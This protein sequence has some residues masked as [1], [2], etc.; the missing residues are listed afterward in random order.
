M[1]FNIKNKVIH[2]SLS[3]L[4]SL[5]I[6]FSVIPV[7]LLVS[8][9]EVMLLSYSAAD[10]LAEIQEN[11]VVP[12]DAVWT[13]TAKRITKNENTVNPTGAWLTP[14]LSL[15]K[16]DNENVNAYL[17]KQMNILGVR[18][19]VSSKDGAVYSFVGS[20][21]GYM[22]A[23][24]FV[25]PLSGEIKLSDINNIGIGSA[26]TGDPF[27]TLH[28]FGTKL[29]ISIYQNDTKIWPSDSEC[30]ILNGERWI[31]GNKVY[32]NITVDFPDLGTL[33]VTKGD[34]IRI[35]CIPLNLE[36]GYI[37]MSPKVDYVSIDEYQPEIVELPSF[38]SAEEVFALQE[39]GRADE[40]TVWTYTPKRVK[41]DE[42]DGL[43][44]QTGEWLYPELEYGR[45]DN[46]GVNSLLPKQMNISGKRSGIASD[47]GK[48]YTF[49]GYGDGYSSTLTFVA[50]L[51]GKIKLTDPNGIGIGS[52]GTGDPFW[53]LHE[54]KEIGVVIFKN[55]EK[56]WPLDQGYHLLKGN[57]W[58]TNP[59]TW[60][61]LTTDFPELG[62]LNV[63]KGDEIHISVIPLS[64]A[65]GYVA[66]S[67]TAEYIEVDKIQPESTV[68]YKFK[69]FSDIENVLNNDSFENTNW[70]VEGMACYPDANGLNVPD[71][72]WIG[73][74]LTQGRP[75]S[76]EI[77]DTIPDWM[78]LNGSQLGITTYNKSVILSAGSSGV[79]FAIAL[80][81][82]APKSGKVDL[83]DP[84]GGI[85]GSAGLAAPFWTLNE[86]TKIAGLAIYKN[87]EKIWPLED[88]YYKLQ[89]QWDHTICGYNYDNEYEVIF[90]S[91]KNIEVNAGD[92][93]RMCVIPVKDTWQYISLSPQVKYTEIDLDSTVTESDGLK[94]P[95][96][97]YRAVDIVKKAVE[98][99]VFDD[100]I[101]D[102]NAIEF[103]ES[104]LIDEPNE[105]SV[106]F[107]DE[108]PFIFKEMNFNATP[109]DVKCFTVPLTDMSIAVDK[110]D[111]L[112]LRPQ[113]GTYYSAV[114]FKA[115]KT[116][117]IRL[118]SNDLNPGFA[119]YHQWSPYYTLQ[120]TFDPDDGKKIQLY[121]YKNST[122]IWP[123]NANEP[124][125]L[126][127]ECRTLPFPDMEF[128]I[129][130]G[131]EIR[132]LITSDNSWQFCNFDPVIDYLKYN[133]EI[134][135]END[136][137]GWNIGTKAG[138][139]VW[140]DFETEEE[141]LEEIK[142]NT[143]TDNDVV[144]NKDNISDKDENEETTKKVAK[145]IIKRRYFK[146]NYTGIII[147]IVS[148]SVVVILS[149]TG[150]ILFYRKKKKLLKK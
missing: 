125:T 100:P 16:S 124:N 132:F 130:E 32:G 105:L 36:W 103:K 43:Y 73:L 123:T 76:D 22:G 35:A 99:G 60:G 114:V 144:Q 84:A 77:Y 30:H 59:P 91:I 119:A 75:S 134:R 148:I 38:S 64:L 126:T 42:T 4:V 87:D 71:G 109:F 1:K 56:I 41:R 107:A 138:D 137:T 102:F 2:I 63:K 15:G 106:V 40:N 52:A 81:F 90:P 20:G 37:K 95:I 34:K 82:V 55:D 13:Y 11:G 86:A 18:N 150:G 118:H 47:G 136:K 14:S 83:S 6:I 101:W 61:N 67:P 21:D 45:S 145:K 108:L 44:K 121:V 23:V 133:N 24:T 7:A 113:C 12:K 62:I 8:G 143:S 98:A 39:S 28:Q 88:D 74:E 33:R 53:T 129:Y 94:T 27:W 80:T 139:I 79:D 70:T 17:P 51:S 31:G 96:A 58:A 141:I 131:D 115:P 49:A 104:M 29:G 19:G 50:P 48:V 110:N 128:Q 92:K 112:L 78:M 140:E 117:I 10:V 122:Q 149:V 3:M 72:K 9:N 66:L 89:G 65:W 54:P 147:I 5:T 25:A 93:L 26:G 116:G 57:N 97:S 127:N 142:E 120:D 85:F 46:E 69:A 111:R 135:P 146:R 68:Q